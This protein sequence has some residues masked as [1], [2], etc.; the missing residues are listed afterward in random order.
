[1]CLVNIHGL[2][3]LPKQLETVTDKT[4][5]AY[6]AKCVFGNLLSDETEKKDFINIKT[7]ES[8]KRDRAEKK[9]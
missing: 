4:C 9:K 8:K 6:W 2:E 1:M 7:N 5:P 3:S